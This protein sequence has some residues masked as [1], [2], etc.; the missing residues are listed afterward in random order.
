MFALN[1]GNFKI[2]LYFLASSKPKSN[3]WFPTAIASYFILFKI[4]ARA[5]PF[6]ELEIG[7]P[8]NASPASK[9]TVVWSFLARSFSITVANLAS[10]T[11]DVVLSRP[12]SSTIRPWTSLVCTNT[13]SFSVVF[14]AAA[15][16]GAEESV[17]CAAG[18]TSPVLGATEAS[19]GSDD[20]AATG[21]VAGAGVDSSAN[22]APPEVAIAKPT[23]VA[24]ASV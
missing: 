1:R 16:D 13:K 11:T 20:G 15:E 4:S 23:I 14:G 18:F 17:G 21:E 3:S 9:T 24:D 8:W 2:S 10:P 19:D 12:F 22:A 6:V 5:S 7:N